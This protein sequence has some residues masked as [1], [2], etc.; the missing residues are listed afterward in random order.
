MGNIFVYL[1]Y[2]LGRGPPWIFGEFLKMALTYFLWKARVYALFVIKE[3]TILW[4]S[5]GFGNVENK[6]R[7][8]KIRRSKTNSKFWFWRRK[9]LRTKI[10][11]V[12]NLYPLKWITSPRFGLLMEQVRVFCPQQFFSVPG[13]FF[14]GVSFPL[15]FIEPCDLAAGSAFWLIQNPD[16]AFLIS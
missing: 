6:K 14:L 15:H 4:E 2:I 5:W 7:E 11:D 3:K 10:R 1:G 13:S 12:T 9:F 8:A 16:G